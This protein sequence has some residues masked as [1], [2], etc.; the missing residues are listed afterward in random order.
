MFDGMEVKDRWI[1]G[2]S[3][4]DFEMFWGIA[5]GCEAQV[6]G[7]YDSVTSDAEIRR[8]D[9]I[10]Q[11]NKCGSVFYAKLELF[12]ISKGVSLIYIYS[13]RSAVPFWRKMGYKPSECSEEEFTWGNMYKK[14]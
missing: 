6:K 10:P 11:G 1:D 12:L 5:G 9:V 13:V 14:V 3:S 8:M 7:R 2:E 4:H